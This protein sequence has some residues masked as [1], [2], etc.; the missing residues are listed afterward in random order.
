MNKRN[1]FSLRNQFI[2]TPRVE[3]ASAR[4]EELHADVRRSRTSKGLLL[5]GPS[6]GGKTTL[7]KE[8]ISN[9]FNS[10][11]I[12]G[13]KRTALL[14][15]MPSSPS[16]KSL[17]SAILE[18]L[19]DQFASS[20]SHS[21]EAKFRRVV[22][23]L[24]NLGVEILIFDEVQHLIDFKRSSAYEA[25][26]WIKSLMNELQI[27]VVL[28]GLKRTEGLL[29]AN[30]QLRRRFSASIEFNRYTCSSDAD[31]CEFV[32]LVNSISGI[33]PVPSINLADGKVLQR[34]HHGCFG[35]IDYLIKILDR[36]IW[37]VQSGRVAGIELPVLADAFLDEVWS[38][39]PDSRNPFS[40]NF[41][42][43]AL[44]GIHEPFENFDTSTA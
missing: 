9:K 21:A 14:V 36:A 32:A 24:K 3:L 25:A 22:V 8:C 1:E 31:L 30:E 37:L 44:I 40:T 35:L 10:G 38:Q 16:K 34:L 5:L 27:A 39:A 42:F 20:R 33:V 19:G 12:L 2:E 43:E 11:D 4:I 13:R 41:N 28:V 7:I 18:A 15:N 6:G 17:A 29:W 23:L 26:D